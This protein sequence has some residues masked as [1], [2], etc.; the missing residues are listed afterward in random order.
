MLLLLLDSRRHEAI[1]VFEIRANFTGDD[2][3]AASL[4]GSGDMRAVIIGD[5]DAGAI[6]LSQ[7][8]IQAK[9]LN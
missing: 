9:L 5:D 8:E 3:V 1:I 7:S 4:T 2:E 6:K